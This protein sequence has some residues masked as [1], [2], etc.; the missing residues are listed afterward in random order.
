LSKSGTGE[1]DDIR[2]AAY[3]AKGLGLFVRSLVGM[4]RSAAKE[5][6]ARFIIIDKTFTANQLEFINLIVDHLTEH[7]VME[8]A[9]LYESPFT[10][11]AP[12]GHDGLFKAAEIDE[13]LQILDGVRATASE[14][15]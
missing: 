2:R 7:G 6:L 1:A 5:A 12:Y 14:A 8:P 9:R 11:I 10:D 15:A 4:D 13:L 3:E